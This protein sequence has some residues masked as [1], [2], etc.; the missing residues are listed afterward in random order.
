MVEIVDLKTDD[1]TIAFWEL[2]WL[3]YCLQ[4]DAEVV[5]IS[6][7]DERWRL[8]GDLEAKCFTI[9]RGCSLNTLAEENDFVNGRNRF[10]HFMFLVIMNNYDS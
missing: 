2:V 6:K 3:F 4:I 1:G 7:L 9:D 10:F 5:R 8:K